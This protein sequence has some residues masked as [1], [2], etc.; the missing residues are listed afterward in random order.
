MK[1]LIIGNGGREHAI[2]WKVAQNENVEKIY[3]APGNAGTYGENKCENIDIKGNE[4]L[5]EFAKK[6]YIDITIVGPEAPL[7]DGIVDMFQNEGLKIFG[8]SKKAANLEGSKAFAKEFMK[9]YGVKTADYEVFTDG[10]S[11]LKY[12]KGCTYPRVIKADGLAGGKGVII[13]QSLE[14]AEDA[15][16]DFM[17]NDVLGDSGKTVVVEEF[18]EGVEASIL[19][20]TDGERVIPFI[21]SKDHKTIFDDNKGPN[22]GGMGAIAPN[23]YCTEKVLKEFEKD[24]MIPTLNGIKAEHMDYKGIIFFGLMINDRGVYLLEY[25]VRMGDPETQV[26][27]PLMKSDFI[28]LIECAIDVKLSSFNIEWFNKSS[29]CIVAASKGYPLSYSTG[30]EIS[31]INSVKNKVFIAGAVNKDNRILTSGGRVLALCAVGENIVEAR[32]G[33]YEEI[34]KIQFEGIYFRK[35]IGRI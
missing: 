7:V 28:D 22:T 20:I 4:K 16:K 19:S 27:L 26:V 33:A 8:P 34:K 10:Q 15:I 23:P 14:E 29:C 6:N 3:C 18:L 5:L 30:F 13:C 31:N 12:L 32:Q 35:D 1:V 24:I 17:I 25:N 11:A 21:S 9:K 2:A